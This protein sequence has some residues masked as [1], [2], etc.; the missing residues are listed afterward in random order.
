VH[1]DRLADLEYVA[2]HHGKQGQGYVYELLYDG[3]GQDGQP[4]LTGLIDLE[5]LREASATETSRGAAP[6]FAGPSRAENGPL[7]GGWR[8][9]SAA[10]PP[11]PEALELTS[12]AAQAENARLGPDDETTSYRTRVRAKA[13]GRAHD[14]AR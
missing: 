11:A 4:F 1:L 10:L 6:H 14:T 12:S 2:V 8:E 13:N 3:Q 9:P 7:A 5:R